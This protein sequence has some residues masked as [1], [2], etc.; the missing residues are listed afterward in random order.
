MKLVQQVGQFPVDKG[1]D[2]VGL[3]DVWANKWLSGDVNKTEILDIIYKGKVK[4]SSL[5][6]TDL[7]LETSNLVNLEISSFFW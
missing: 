5:A 2:K 6:I 7:K 1:G 4:I 3:V